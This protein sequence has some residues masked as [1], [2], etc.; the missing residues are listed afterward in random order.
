MSQ[1][2]NKQIIINDL[3]INYYQQTTDKQAPTLLFL[4]GWRSAGKIWNS[5]IEKLGNGYNI[6]SLD[7]PGFGQS[8]VPDKNF[9][10]QDYAEV[11]DG[12]IQKNNLSEVIIIGH[13]FGGRIAI[14]L[15]AT[16]PKYLYKLVLVDSAG[17]RHASAGRIIKQGIAK[18]LKPFFKLPGL[19]S[20]R[21]K[22]YTSMGAEDYLATPELQAIFV[23]IV[24]E[25]ITSLLSKIKISTMLI[26]GADDNDTPLSDAKIMKE[27]ITD[28]KL[29][30]LSDA[31]HF[32]F[33]DQT[34]KFVSEIREFLV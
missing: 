5:V 16:N 14:K 21:Q 3:L 9:N 13:S 20:A 8:N 24:K 31:G 23:N 26:W 32:S 11:V 6:Y 29:V 12:F 17:I 4:H 22:I 30:V 19:K 25:D 7:L 1:L 2:K 28:S 18:L 27:K 10:L 33:L 15:A 34:E